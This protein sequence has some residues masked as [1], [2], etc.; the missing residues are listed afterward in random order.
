MMK[1]PTI[2]VDGGILFCNAEAVIDLFEN[3][4]IY[5]DTLNIAILHKKY[6]VL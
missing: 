4:M 6:P 1:S 3:K 5:I 2:N